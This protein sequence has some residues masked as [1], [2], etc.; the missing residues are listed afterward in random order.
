MGERTEAKQSIESSTRHLSDIAQEL[1]RR[2]TPRYIGDQA[3]ETALNK[4]NEWKEQIGTSPL[5]LGLIGGTIGALIGR[6]FAKERRTAVYERSFERSERPYYRSPVVDGRGQPYV[7]PGWNDGARDAG[8]RDGNG[9][10]GGIADK[11]SG[12]GDKVSGQAQHLVERA[13]DFRDKAGDLAMNVRDSIPSSTELTRK[14]EENPMVVA[15]GGLALGAVAALLLPVSRKEREML[16][17]LKQRAG[18]AIGTL[19]DKIG[20][21]AQQAREQIAGQQQ[22]PPS[23]QPQQTSL[24]ATDLTGAITH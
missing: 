19:G 18:E 3:K 7:E 16:D 24:V 8:S 12:I 2:A 14:G 10:G 22:P 1:S 13:H 4:T 11:V 9:I 17:P 23:S 6:A 21:T 15:L 5:A 20:E